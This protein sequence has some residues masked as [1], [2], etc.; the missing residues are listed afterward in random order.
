[1]SLLEDWLNTAAALCE[2]RDCIS[3]DEPRDAES[4]YFCG[5]CA[6]LIEPTSTHFQPPQ[7]RAALYH[8]GGPLGT[9]IHRFKY[10]GRTD[11]AGPLARLMLP[12]AARYRGKV[13]CVMP[14]PL[15]RNRLRERGYNQ[16]AL[17][18]RP[19]AKA[20]SVPLRWD[21]RRVQHSAPQV[22]LTT[23][24]RAQNIRDAFA[25]LT[26]LNGARVLLIDDVMTTGATLSAGSEALRDAGAGALFTLTLARAELE[27]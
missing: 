17:L 16:A 13:D 11:L 6:I 10:R 19:I 18:A 25:C 20:L 27:K 8:Y 23:S 3:C 2:A 22:G 12:A 26:D 4:A 15:H 14:M 9:A 7:K 24:E 1:M 21:L 5:G